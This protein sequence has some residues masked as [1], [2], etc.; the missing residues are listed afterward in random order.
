[1]SLLSF[2]CYTLLGN[3]LTSEKAFVSLTLFNIL[4]FPL[5]MLP[6]M[7]NQLIQVR[8]SGQIWYQGHVT[9]LTNMVSRSCHVTSKYGVGHVVTWLLNMVFWMSRDFQISCHLNPIWYCFCVMVLRTLTTDQLLSG[10][11][12]YKSY[13]EVPI[14]PRTWSGWRIK[15]RTQSCKCYF[16]FLSRCWE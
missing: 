9:W 4:R 15:R 13:S 3:T 11:S 10:E 7:I 6:N 14:A 1:M 8:Y 2:L 5:V 12:E 16:K